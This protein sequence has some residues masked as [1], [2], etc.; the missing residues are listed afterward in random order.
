MERD[1]CF[2][3]RI[4]LVSFQKMNQVP[5]D[6]CFGEFKQDPGDHH[7]NEACADRWQTHQGERSQEEEEAD[8]LQGHQDSLSWDIMETAMIQYYYPKM[9]LLCLRMELHVHSQF[10]N[11]ESKCLFLGGGIKCIPVIGDSMIL[12]CHTKDYFY[13]LG[14]VVWIK[15]D[16]KIFSSMM[17]GYF[18]W[19]NLT[20]SI[21]MQQYRF[22]H[23][24][25]TLQKALAVETIVVSRWKREYFG[26][27][28]T[29]LVPHSC[30]T[31]AKLP[32]RLWRLGR[33]VPNLSGPQLPSI[34]CI[35][36]VLKQDSWEFMLACQPLWQSQR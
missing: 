31:W 9:L 18:G 27:L 14:S 30:L 8:D 20:G 17:G 6:S 36:T 23:K 15:D 7:T 33:P 32:Y 3:N 16:I 12:F 19:T 1:W 28:L 25:S 4:M 11:A 13:L 24:I 10:V 34:V 2:S 29:K 26:V 5:D 22:R 35:G 21:Q